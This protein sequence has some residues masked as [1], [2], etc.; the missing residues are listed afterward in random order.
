MGTVRDFTDDFVSKDEFFMYHELQCKNSGP[1]WR[2][3]FTG[4]VAPFILFHKDNWCHPHGEMAEEMQVKSALTI[5]PERRPFC[6]ICYKE[7]SIDDECLQLPC[8]HQFHRECIHN[9]VKTK[10]ECPTCRTPL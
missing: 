10:M 1:L 9:W 4:T 7:V 3:K 2:W 6:V 5:L 8:S